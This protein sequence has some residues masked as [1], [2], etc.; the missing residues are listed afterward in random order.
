MI[1]FVVTLKLEPGDYCIVS[2]SNGTIEV[3]WL[4]G[5]EPRDRTAVF[6]GLHVDGPGPNAM[7]WLALR[8]LARQVMEKLDV[9]ILRVEG[10]PRT[11]G[12]GPGRRPAPI[13]FRRPGGAGS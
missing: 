3:E 9:D 2:L 11:T 7:G 10:A 6:Q 4:F 13:V 1:W 8:D 5:F 12:A